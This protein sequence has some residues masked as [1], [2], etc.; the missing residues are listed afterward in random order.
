KL[1]TRRIEAEHA[2]ELKGPKIQGK[3]IGSTS[4]GHYAKFASIPLGEVGAVKVRVSS[5]GSG[6]KIELHAG[7]PDGPLMGSIDVPVT[8]GWDKFEEH[9][10]PLTPAS[11]DRA[12]IY[13]VFI[14]PGKGGLMNLDWVEFAK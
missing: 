1:R 7:S 3:V 8:G 11:K 13:V 14:N 12:D 10:T 4:H 6:G 5:G 2:E 9:K